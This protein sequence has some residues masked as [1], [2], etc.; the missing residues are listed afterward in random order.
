MT[1]TGSTEPIRVFGCV[2]CDKDIRFYKLTALGGGV[3]GESQG[4]LAAVVY[5]SPSCGA[6]GCFWTFVNVT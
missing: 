1:G 6:S 5:L 2:V 4:A 3:A